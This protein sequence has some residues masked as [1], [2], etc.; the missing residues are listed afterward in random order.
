VF[1]VW[2]RNNEKVF[3]SRSAS[4]SVGQYR[5]LC[6]L[7]VVPVL[8]AAHSRAVP[9]TL[10]AAVSARARVRSMR[11]RAGNLRCADARRAV[12]A[13]AAVVI[14]SALA[15]IRGREKKFFADV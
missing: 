8:P 12:H 13:A 2:R 3:A 11:H 4:R 5:W 9:A 7:F 10:S 1:L 6:L 15:E 14:A